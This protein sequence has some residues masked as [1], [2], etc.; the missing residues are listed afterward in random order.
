[1][2]SKEQD[3]GSIVELSD[4]HEESEE[5]ETVNEDDK[6]DKEGKETATTPDQQ[7]AAAP[8]PPP[9]TASSKSSKKKAKRKKK[10]NKSG[11]GGGSTH[12]STAMPED[13]I[14]EGQQPPAPAVPVRPIDDIDLDD[15]S[16]VTSDSKP[17]KT[18]RD[19]F[20]TCEN[21]GS[22]IVERILVCAGCKKVAYCNFRCQKANWKLHKKTCSYALKKDVK[23]CTG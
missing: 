11:T 12:C 19:K 6:T 13:D 5:E 23:D 20:K 18:A 22:E 21:C 16:V 4:D 10:K 3:D 9:T 15:S 17:R 7:Q 8:D 1:M 14:P 2:F